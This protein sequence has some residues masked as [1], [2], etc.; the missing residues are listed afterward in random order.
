VQYA[1][2]SIA[3]DFP[4]R[5]VHKTKCPFFTKGWILSAFLFSFGLPPLMRTSRSTWLYDNIP[6]ARP[7]VMP[8]N[9]TITRHIIRN[10]QKSNPQQGNSYSCI[11]LFD[12]M[13]WTIGRN[14]L[15]DEKMVTL[16][17]ELSSR[18]WLFKRSDCD[19]LLHG[20]ILTMRKR[21]IDRY[22]NIYS[23]CGQYSFAFQVE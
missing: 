17:V 10:N 8:P 22:K 9:N 11:V 23:S 4:R 19:Y 5:R 7:D 12:V 6:K 21:M 18:G 16:Y 13:K 1:Y 14:K 3:N 20:Y 15:M 2:T